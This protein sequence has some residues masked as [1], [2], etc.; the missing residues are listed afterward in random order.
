MD[1]LVYLR[2]VLTAQG[3][4]AEELECYLALLK[5]RAMSALDV[6][7]SSRIPRTS[8]YRALDSLLGRGLVSEQKRNRRTVYA[9][10]HPRVLLHEVRTRERALTEA[11]PLFEEMLFRHPAYPTTK[12]FT[13]AKGFAAAFESFYDEVQKEKVKQIH[14][15]SHPDLI[16]RYPK[17]FAG[18]VKRRESLK[19]H[20]FLMMPDRVSH[21]RSPLLTKNLLRDVRYVPQ[22]FI[23]NTSML[24]GGSTVLYIS[25]GD[26]EPYAILVHSAPIAYLLREFFKVV[27]DRV[28][29][30]KG[31]ER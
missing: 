4:S 1:T 20:I 21:P 23:Q 3:L 17:V 2:A 29:I 8:V 7:R 18:S 9:A 15:L 28:A 22:A 30:V 11:I 24:I 25:L 13:G 16:K 14:S 19:A 31:G 27:W 10:E 26:K 6:S 5:G 12:V